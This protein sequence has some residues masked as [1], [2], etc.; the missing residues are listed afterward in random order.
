MMEKSST[1][2]IALL[3][4]LSSRF[5]SSPY[6]QSTKVWIHEG[7]QHK[8]PEPAPVSHSSSKQ[9][10]SCLSPTFVPMTSQRSRN[11]WQENKE[12]VSD[13]VHI[14]RDTGWKGILKKSLQRKYISERSLA[15]SH[16][17]ELTESSTV[18][19]LLA[20]L[21]VA[22]GILLAI[23]RDTI[24]EKVSNFGKS[25]LRFLVLSKPTP[26]MSSD[27]SATRS[28]RQASFLMDV[29]HIAHRSVLLPAVH[30]PNVGSTPRRRSLR[31][32]DRTRCWISSPPY[33]RKL[34]FLGFQNA[35]RKESGQVSFYMR[36]LDIGPCSCRLT[37][38]V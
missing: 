23:F 32:Q 37:K 13:L 4:L 16:F 7:S 21:T 3:I 6:L 19:W 34:V 27:Y 5:P 17:V 29:T 1:D 36:G 22:G 2:L 14:I 24:V 9:A 25:S 31:T 11:W 33:R 26:S 35:F 15:I 30:R 20:I 18:W 28:D 10:V 38:R 8:Q 12:A